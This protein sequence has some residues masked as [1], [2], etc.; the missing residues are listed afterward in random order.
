MFMC[1]SC[2]SNNT[3]HFDQTKC[4]CNAFAIDFVVKNS[5]KYSKPS[6]VGQVSKIIIWKIWYF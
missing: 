3:D 5:Q 6:G 2:C 4:H 1:G